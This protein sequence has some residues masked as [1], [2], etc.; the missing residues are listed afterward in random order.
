[1]EHIVQFAIG[2]DDNT[3][4][5]IVLEEAS[6][7]IIDDIEKDVRQKMFA[8]RYYGEVPSNKEPLSVFVENIIANFLESNKNDII[9]KAA[10]ILANRLARTKAAKAAMADALEV[11]K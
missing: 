9:S 1:M 2:I 10:E 3:I 5:Q 4:K 11:S 6:K 8:P 7:T